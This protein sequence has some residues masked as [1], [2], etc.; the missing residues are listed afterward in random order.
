MISLGF[1]SVHIGPTSALV[2]SGNCTISP[3]ALHAT[4]ISMCRKLAR[5][6]TLGSPILPPDAL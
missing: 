4:A 1:A 3:F 2:Y 6:S 5:K